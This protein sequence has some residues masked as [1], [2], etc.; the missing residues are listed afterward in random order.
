MTLRL[1]LVGCGEH[2]RGSHAAPLARYAAEHP[3]EIT[4]AAA[5]DLDIARA[6]EFRRDFG[7]QRAYSSLQEMLGREQLDGCV[8]VMPVGRIGEVA[9]T[10]LECRI[11]CVIEKPV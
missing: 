8:S 6:E 2:S 4:L 11:P 3:G 1:A 9:A 10:L 7:F 5:C